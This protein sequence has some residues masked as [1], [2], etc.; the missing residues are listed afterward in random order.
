MY[1]LNVSLAFCTILPIIIVAVMAPT[2]APVGA[3]KASKA[4]KAKTLKGKNG[5]RS[6]PANIFTNGLR[7]TTPPCNAPGYMHV[8]DTS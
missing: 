8:D 4:T 7:K 2:T 1:V 6:K 3:S 5:S